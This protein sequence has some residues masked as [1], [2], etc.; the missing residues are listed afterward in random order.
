MRRPG[1]PAATCSISNSG[2]SSAD[3]AAQASDGLQSVEIFPVER[4]VQTLPTIVLTAG[5]VV[6]AWTGSS[7]AKVKVS[8]SITQA[9]APAIERRL[10]ISRLPERRIHWR[11]SYSIGRANCAKARNS[12]ISRLWK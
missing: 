9:A 10:V 12:A 7:A 3:K 11:T 6:R 4:L 8:E 1:V 5:Q 2:C